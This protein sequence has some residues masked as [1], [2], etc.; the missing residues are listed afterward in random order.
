MLFKFVINKKLST[1]SF[2]FEKDPES[3][4]PDQENN[5]LGA[6]FRIWIHMFLGLLDPDP[7]PLVRGMDPAPDTSI[8]KQKQKNLDSY[9]FVTSL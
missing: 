1:R 9:C 6:V 4:D 3:L 8:I 5:Y 2:I 7:E